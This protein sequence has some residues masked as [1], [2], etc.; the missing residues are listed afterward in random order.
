M[1]QKSILSGMWFEYVVLQLPYKNLLKSQQ[2]YHCQR[3]ATILPIDG[4]AKIF[5]ILAHCI[6]EKVLYAS[7]SAPL[8]LYRSAS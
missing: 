8:F 6:H 3:F 4:V 2:Y 1:E 5:E 7:H